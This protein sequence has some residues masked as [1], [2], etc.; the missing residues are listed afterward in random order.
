MKLLPA[1]IISSVIF[2]LSSY[3]LANANDPIDDS[4]KLCHHQAVEKS[5]F[6]PEKAKSSNTVA[7]GAGAGA[8]GGTAVRA[9]QGKSLLKGAA[10][11]AGV[12][13]AGGG[14]KKN[15]DKKQ[16]VLSESHYKSEYE[17]CLRSRGLNPENVR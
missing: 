17:N 15:R 1:L 4:K 5:G 6:D 11:G 2:S 14:L 12:G 8:V 16:A 10:I 3:T 9:I 13:A 7:K